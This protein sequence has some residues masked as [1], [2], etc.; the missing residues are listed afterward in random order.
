MLLAEITVL[1]VL[2]KDV[3]TARI[4]GAGKESR[5]I[6]RSLIIMNIIQLVTVAA[7]GVLF[8]IGIRSVLVFLISLSADLICFIIFMEISK[9]ERKELIIPGIRNI[10]LTLALTPLVNCTYVVYTKP[11]YGLEIYQKE[12]AFF[13][14]YVVLSLMLITAIFII[15]RIAELIIKKKKSARSTQPD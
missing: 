13:P 5:K 11:F 3:Y 2:Y 15:S 7:A 10:I 9:N 6:S 14:E 1:I 12:Y 8:V 4:T